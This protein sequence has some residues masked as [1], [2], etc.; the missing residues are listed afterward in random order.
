MFGSSELPRAGMMAVLF[1]VLAMGAESVSG[2]ASASGLDRPHFGIGYAAN[3]PN[4]MAGGGGYVVTPY[5]GGIGLYLDA[6]FDVEDPSGDI[7]FEKGLTADDV[8]N[9][10]EGAEFIKRES[11]YRSFNAA[12]VK[13][14]TPYLMVYAGGGLVQRSRFHWYEAPESDLGVSGI[15]WVRAPAE[16]D[17]MG[18]FMLGMFM[19]VSSFLSTQ[20][21]LETEPRGFTIGVSLRL[22]RS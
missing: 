2:Q 10:V 17:T 7:A 21:G 11:S 12:L 15:F 5:F 6:K 8:V 4:L 9:E 13:P 22:P 14:V 1:C 18:N 16:D 20:V 19:R 3:A